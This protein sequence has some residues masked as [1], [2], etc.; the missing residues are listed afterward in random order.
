MKQRIVSLAATPQ[1]VDIDLA[2][3]AL[4]VIDMQNDFCHPNG[5]FAAKGI[6][7]SPVAAVVPMIER[8]TSAIR[9]AGVPVLWL[10]WGLRPDRAN[11]PHLTLAKGRAGGTPTYGDHSASCASFMASWQKATPFFRRSESRIRHH[12]PAN[13]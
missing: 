13:H 12:F 5:W 9:A 11:L 8:M 1:A 2:T 7:A 6:D 4:L 3:T 10:N